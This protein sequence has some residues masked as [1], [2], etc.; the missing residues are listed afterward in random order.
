MLGVGEYFGFSQRVFSVLELEVGIRFECWS[1][2]LMMKGKKGLTLLMAMKSALLCSIST[3]ER[4]L[5]RLKA[6]RFRI[7]GVGLEM[8]RSDPLWIVLRSL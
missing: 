3:A 5:H 7:I 8:L 1:E 6:K 2:R 4:V